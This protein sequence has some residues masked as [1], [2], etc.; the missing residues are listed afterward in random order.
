MKSHLSCLHAKGELSSNR[1]RVNELSS[2]PVSRKQK[3]LKIARVTQKSCFRGGRGDV[4]ST[5]GRTDGQMNRRC[6]FSRFSSNCSETL[7]TFR[8]TDCAKCVVIPKKSEPGERR[9]SK[10]TS[11]QW[12]ISILLCSTVLILRALLKKKN[13]KTK[14]TKKL[15]KKIK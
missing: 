7:W 10:T 9:S 11:S 6:R 14:K 3:L 12:R 8:K 4:P 15:I 5:D 2:K 1:Q 13:K